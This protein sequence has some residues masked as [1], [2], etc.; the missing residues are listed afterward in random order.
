MNIYLVGAYL[1]LYAGNW[2]K[3]FSFS[4]KCLMVFVGLSFLSVAMMDVVGMR[5][6]KGWWFAY[7]FVSDS[8]KILAFLVGVCVFLLFK[9]LPL[10]HSRLINTVAKTTFG[11][12]LI[13][14]HSDAM[15]TFLWQYLAQV[16]SMINV[17]LW[18]L[19][20]HAAGWAFSV[21]LVCSLIDYLRLRYLEPPVMNWIY[22]NSQQ[23]EIK[24]SEIIEYNRNLIRKI[25][26]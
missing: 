10:G 7:Y 3:R 8:S 13:H 23:I 21:F 14:A 18:H 20:L 26:S 17:P 2:S 24:T 25:T 22:K 9:N 16:P 15:R 1:R 19:V 4:A 5:F 12:L 6:H 11:V